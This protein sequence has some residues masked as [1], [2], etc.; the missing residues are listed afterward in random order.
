M[1]VWQDWDDSYCFAIA[2]Q[3]SCCHS[4]VWLLWLTVCKC[5]VSDLGTFL[6]SSCVQLCRWEFKWVEVTKLRH[7]NYSPHTSVQSTTNSKHGVEWWEEQCENHF[8]TEFSPMFFMQWNLYFA[9]YNGQNLLRGDYLLFSVLSPFTLCRIFV[10][11]QNK[12]HVKEWVWVYVCCFSVNYCYFY[13][14]CCKYHIDAWNC[15]ITYLLIWSQNHAAL[16]L[17]SCMD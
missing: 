4:A 14:A 12:V 16:Q 17:L 1:A 2:F 3:S 8:S 9:L 5:H 13:F 7:W 11:F 10:L 15:L 6:W